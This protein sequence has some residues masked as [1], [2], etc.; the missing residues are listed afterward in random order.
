MQQDGFLSVVDASLMPDHGAD[1]ALYQFA[2]SGVEFS[3]PVKVSMLPQAGSLAKGEAGA[4]YQLTREGIWKELP[5]LDEERAVV[6]WT[7]Q[8]GQFKIGKRTIVLP[9]RT[10]L[11]QNYPNPF[12]PS[13]RI[14]FDLGYEDGPEQQASLVI[15]NILGQEVIT[16]HNSVSAPGRY[17]ITWNSVDKRGVQVASGVYFARLTTGTGKN[18]IKKMLLVR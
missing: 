2:T 10:S 1:G 6:S 13:T 4:I 9:R 11:N 17:E 12:N 8:G 5:T 18:M 7:N 16:L 15:Y 3:K 14:V